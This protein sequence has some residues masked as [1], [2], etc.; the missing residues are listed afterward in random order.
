MNDQN[1]YEFDKGTTTDAG[2]MR[3]TASVPSQT[4]KRRGRPKVNVNWPAEQFTF[5]VLTQTNGKLSTSSLRKK[6][7]AELM[8][9]GLMKVGTLKTA[10]G[11]PQD[12]YQKP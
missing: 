8:K 1:N 10:F 9:G 6:M 5:N 2:A 11:R 7:R 4:T 12:L 3:T